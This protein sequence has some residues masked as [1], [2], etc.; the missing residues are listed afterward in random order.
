MS[1][2]TKFFQMGRNSLR[3]RKLSINDE[4]VKYGGGWI[5][6]ILEVWMRKTDFPLGILRD[7]KFSH[8][9]RGYVT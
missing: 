4:M 2:I 8:N 7:V 6:D 3:L 1:D 5:V 9:Q